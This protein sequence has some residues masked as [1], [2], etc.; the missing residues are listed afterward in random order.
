[1]C[2]PW[3]ELEEKDRLE[4]LM[5]LASLDPTPPFSISF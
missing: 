3:K 1:L 5:R 2:R 4:G